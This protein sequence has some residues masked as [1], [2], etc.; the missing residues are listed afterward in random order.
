MRKWSVKYLVGFGAMTINEEEEF[1]HAWTK[2]G[3]WLAFR[4]H[5]GA[6]LPHSYQTNYTYS[7]MKDDIDL[8]KE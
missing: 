7:V 5:H 8:V 4:M 6:D 1:Y 2:F 3:A